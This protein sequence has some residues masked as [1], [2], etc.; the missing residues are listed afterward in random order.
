V[1]SLLLLQVGVVMSCALL[2]NAD[3]NPTSDANRS[4]PVN[5]GLSTLCVSANGRDQSLAGENLD[6]L[7]H[8]RLSAESFQ[9][10]LG[11]IIFAII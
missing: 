10:I 3:S 11:S 2:W 9:V 5:I 6:T 1:G 7:R 4:S 8:E